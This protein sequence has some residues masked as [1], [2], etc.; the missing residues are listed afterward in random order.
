MQIYWKLLKLLLELLEKANLP[1]PL[2]VQ[3]GVQLK[4][5]ENKKYYIIVPEEAT[6]NMP[7]IIYFP[8]G[9]PSE[10]FNTYQKNSWNRS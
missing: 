8:G 7:L 9:N 1:K 10:A 4:T 3:T 5:F 6:E 2:N